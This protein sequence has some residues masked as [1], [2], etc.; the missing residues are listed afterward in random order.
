[1]HILFK[2]L[3]FEYYLFPQIL[4]FATISLFDRVKILYYHRENLIV[5]FYGNIKYLKPITDIPM[6]EILIRD[7][8]IGAGRS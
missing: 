6:T 7:D 3:Y 8:A 1:M 4:I 2:F 5:W